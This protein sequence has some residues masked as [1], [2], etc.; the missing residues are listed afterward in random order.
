MTFL[1]FESFTWNTTHI[2]CF[3]LKILGIQLNTLELNWAR[4]WVV[5]MLTVCQTSQMMPTGTLRKWLLPCSVMDILMQEYHTSICMGIILS[6]ALHISEE[7]I[8]VSYLELIKLPHYSHLLGNYILMEY[9]IT[10]ICNLA[11]WLCNAYT[12]ITI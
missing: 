8:Q 10:K 3:V 6:R 1:I 7:D 12:N 9:Q 2:Q 11:G 4:P 5:L